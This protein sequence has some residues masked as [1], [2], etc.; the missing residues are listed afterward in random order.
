MS[1]EQ[2]DS[3][4]EAASLDSHRGLALVKSGILMRIVKHS[5]RDSQ[6]RV[7]LTITAAHYAEHAVAIEQYRR[8]LL[9]Y[10]GWLKVP[11]VVF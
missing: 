6:S 10:G 9:Q 2:V 7:T 1:A 3:S 5:Y 4:R 8:W 11:V